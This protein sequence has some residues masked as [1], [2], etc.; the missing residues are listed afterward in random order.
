MGRDRLAAQGAEG[1]P[2]GVGWF[3]GKAP[4][5]RKGARLAPQ[6]MAC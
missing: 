3:R 6:V 5:G 1:S 4:F 2:P